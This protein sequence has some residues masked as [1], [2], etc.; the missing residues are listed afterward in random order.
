M[1]QGVIVKREV[2]G[3]AENEDNHPCNQ[4]HF[5]NEVWKRKRRTNT[6]PVTGIAMS[7]NQ[8][9]TL[10]LEIFDKMMR[11]IKQMI[12][13]RTFMF[14]ILNRMVGKCLDFESDGSV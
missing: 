5:G 1:N 2:E 3:G 7:R 8:S 6:N 12:V 9:L 10:S 11:K 13:S 4:I 14:G